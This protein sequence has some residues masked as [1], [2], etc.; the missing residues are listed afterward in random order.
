[1]LMIQSCPKL[2]NAT[3]ATFRSTAKSMDVVLI[4]NH[5]SPSPEPSALNR[6]PIGFQ[7]LKAQA[8]SRSE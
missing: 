5:H 1:M 6:K 3:T 7:S 2:L 4:K 8:Q